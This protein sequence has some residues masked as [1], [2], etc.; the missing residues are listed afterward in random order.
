MNEGWVKIHRKIS[1]NPLWTCE[2]FTRGQAWIDLILLANH[3]KGYFYKRGVKININRGQSGY[4]EV[5]LSDRWKWSRSK[6]RKF[7][8][9]LEEEQQIKQIKNNVSLVVT[10]LNYDNYQSKE[11]QTKQQK[12]TKKTSERQQKDTNK[13]EKN[14]KNEKK[15][16][17]EDQFELFWTQ[18]H[19]I[20]RIAKTDKDP[21]FNKFKKLTL[22]ERRK[23]Y[24]MI[25]NYSD[26]I[27][28]KE[29]IKKART[30]LSDKCFNDEFKF[31]ML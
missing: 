1:N 22:D 5:A 4:S 10:I 8:K 27:K 31:I 2:K 24:L 15:L 14:E 11:Q 30:Y 13:N 26:S 28:D 9:E 23:S 18:Y 19:K 17:D 7:L 12:D 6:V 20:T 25:K 16:S 3:E 29:Y 21:A